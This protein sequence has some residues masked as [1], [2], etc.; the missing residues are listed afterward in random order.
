MVKWVMGFKMWTWK[1]QCLQ[2]STVSFT[3][4]HKNRRVEMTTGNTFNTLNPQLIKYT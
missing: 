4:D 2:W 1:H 3:K